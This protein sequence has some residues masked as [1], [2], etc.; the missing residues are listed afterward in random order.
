MDVMKIGSQASGAGG[1]VAAGAPEAVAA[2]ISMLAQGG[3]AADAAAATL[4]AMTITDYG[5][6]AI[7][8]EIPLIIYDAAKQEAKVLRGQGGAPLAAKAID[9]YRAYGIPSNGGQSWYGQLAITFGKLIETE[10]QTRRERQVKIQTARDRFYK[11][12]IADALESFYISSGSFLRK[13]DLAAH[14][15][16]VEEAVSVDYRGYTV[17]KCNTWT[18]G[19]CLCQAL[20]ILEGFDVKKM[21]HLSS[22]CI[23]LLT[24]TLKL[25]L[26]DRDEYYAD[27]AF[28]D[29]P[30][31][32]LLCDEYTQLRR[33]LIDM[34][35]ASNEIRPGD[36]VN[37]KAVKTAGF[38]EPWQGGT[39]TCVTA[40]RWGNMVSATPSCNMPYVV[41]DELGI[42]HGNRLRSLNTTPGHPNHIEPGKL[43][44]ITLT[45]TLV[46]KDG[47]AV[48]GISVVGG[49]IQ[50]QTA[51]NILVNHIDFGMTVAEAVSAPRFGTGHH[52]DSFKSNANRDETITKLAGLKL[53]AGIDDATGAE[54]AQRG[55][56]VE[57]SDAAIGR[58]VMLYRDPATGMID[59]AGEA[60]TGRHAAA[61]P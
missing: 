61:I 33:G 30:L 10:R 6:Y 24:E 12:D 15:T 34:T 42:A 31:K 49:D 11:G 4:L 21:G 22:D 35:K 32:E 55:H 44:R 13:E 46:L 1:A 7:G 9:W 14:E 25:A 36:P 28:V 57:I 5:V 39:T 41:C 51:L 60:R 37:M 47:K 29:V 52:R 27:P 50:D 59:A 56:I 3:N 23:H 38:Y 58:P 2:G 26:A 43:P 48:I 20:R 18:Q 45:P 40:D 17:L 8:G 19:P 16:A 54:L 53:D